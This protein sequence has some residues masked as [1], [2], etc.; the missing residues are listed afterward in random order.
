[1]SLEAANGI[2]PLC[3]PYNL[4]NIKKDLKSKLNKYSIFKKNVIIYKIN[5]KNIKDSIKYYKKSF[6][7]YDY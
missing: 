6:F 3:K 4:Y 7:F 1:M 2:E 5:L